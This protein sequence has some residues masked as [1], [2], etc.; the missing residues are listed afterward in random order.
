MSEMLPAKNSPT[1]GEI[2]VPAA[3][4][5]ALPQG[6]GAAGASVARIMGALIALRR[7]WLRALVAGVLAAGLVGAVIWFVVPLPGWS[8]EVQLRL[9]AKPLLESNKGALIDVAG[10]QKEQRFIVTSR[11]VLHSALLDPKTKSL[12]IVHQHG[13]P[14][15]WLEK[16]LKAEFVATEILRISLE[17]DQPDEMV[18]LVKAIAD[19]YR[20]EF[21]EKDRE[22]RRQR[23]AELQ[24]AYTTYDGKLHDQRAALKL[25]VE[26]AGTGDAKNFANKQENALKQLGE[27]QK[28]ATQYQAE[29][30][31]LKVE[32]E[33]EQRRQRTLPGAA[34]Y[35]SVIRERI[36]HDPLVQKSTQLIAELEMEVERARQ[37]TTERGFAIRGAK[38]QEDLDAANKVLE[39]RRQKLR[40][41]LEA[42]VQG[43]AA[44]QARERLMSLRDKL[45]GIEKLK[46]Q[47][48]ADIKLFDKQSHTINHQQ[49]GVEELKTAISDLDDICKK[50]A[51]RQ[52]VLEVENMAPSP[53]QDVQEAYATPSGFSKRVLLTVAA[54]VALFALAVAGVTWLELRAQRV[55][56]PEEVVQQLGVRL[57]GIMP[58]LSSRANF[59]TRWG[60]TAER[61]PHG[62]VLAESVS[63]ARTMLLHAAEQEKL[64]VIM[65]TSAVSGEGKTSLS[66]QLAASLARIGKKTLLL[67]FDLRNG[68]LHRTFNTPPA[69]GLSEVLRG[70][71]DV[72]DAV[73]AV[74]FKGLS[75]VPAGQINDET[76]HALAQDGRLRQLF[77]L[78]RPYYDFILVDSSPVLPVADALLVAKHVD[79][80]V[81]SVLREVSQLP[82]MY[83]ACQRLAM[84]NVRVLG[85]VVNGVSAE[86]YGYGYQSPACLPS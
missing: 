72:F 17:G 3:T 1:S 14:I 63:T 26:S 82:K 5:P 49:A 21:V 64:R 30:Q 34:L 22:D 15:Q 19:A 10:Y 61:Y 32:L 44:G 69:P 50:I 4:V 78:L 25:L 29:L 55:N 18:V 36:D 6:T 37:N 77:D 76:L 40:A 86:A 27:L 23:L 70:E 42:E 31:R 43:E 46:A 59:L 80:V 16:K 39:R 53:V 12:G 8:A 84:L 33:T 2:V 85:A 67:D 24:K 83:T 60:G 73:Q 57:V 38:L 48:D 74:H 45:A 81:F 75:L 65:V 54:A 66:A 79:G 62:S 9:Q 13:D 20:R 52:Q 47:V 41:V 7:C 71:L 58:Y 51:Q 68:N 35:E 11:L 56:S 28:Y